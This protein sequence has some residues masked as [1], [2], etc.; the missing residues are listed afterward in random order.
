MAKADGTGANASATGQNQTGKAAAAG[1]TE[2]LRAGVTQDARKSGDY[3]SAPQGAKG[4]DSPSA[5]A[6]NQDWAITA[7][8]LAEKQEKEKEEIKPPLFELLIEQFNSLWRASAKAIDAT[9]QAQ[10]LT[11]ATRQS[12]QDVTNKSSPLVY[13]DPSKV[14]KT[15]SAEGA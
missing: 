7:K 14:R 15:S 13:T 6:S 4:P 8:A 12:Q 3:L 9:T 2:P 1:T 11:E 5:D 10:A